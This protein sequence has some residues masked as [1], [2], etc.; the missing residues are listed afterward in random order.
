MVT[1]LIIKVNLSNCASPTWKRSLHAKC[2]QLCQLFMPFI[3]V[4]GRNI[5]LTSVFYWQIKFTK[6]TPFKNRVFQMSK[7]KTVSKTPTLYNFLCVSSGKK[8]WYKEL[9]SST[10]VCKILGTKQHISLFVRSHEPTEAWALTIRLC[11]ANWTFQI[12]MYFLF[13]VRSK[14]LLLILETPLLLYVH[15]SQLDLFM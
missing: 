10:C 8:K 15:V 6:E 1:D 11:K 4:V 5:T 2:A 7:Q 9:P 14:N 3:C 12:L 13:T